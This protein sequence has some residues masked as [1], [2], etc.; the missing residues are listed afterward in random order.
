M[1]TQSAV[2]LA[3]VFHETYERRATE[4]GY[5][6]RE[7]TKQFNEDSPHGRLMIAVCEDVLD[8]LDSEYL[9]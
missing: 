4:F 2:R 9:A 1:S 8:W 7:D 5:E 3:K 6:T